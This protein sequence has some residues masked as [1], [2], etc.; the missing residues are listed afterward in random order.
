[1]NDEFWKDYA[2]GAATVVG[3]LLLV[4]IGFSWFARSYSSCLP[5]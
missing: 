4:G 2:A 1:M 5:R 3:I